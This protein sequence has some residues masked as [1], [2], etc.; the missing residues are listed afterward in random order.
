MAKLIGIVGESGTGKSTSLCATPKLGIKGLNPAET[1]VVNVVGESKD[2]PLKGWMKHYTAFHPTEN[3]EGNYISTA[4]PVKICY[5]VEQMGNR[6]DIKNIVI[7]DW[8]Y[9]MATEF[10]DNAAKAGFEKF[11]RLAANAWKVIK[12]CMAVPTDKKI[13]FLMHPEVIHHENGTVSYKIKTIGKMVDDKITMEGLFQTIIYCKQDYSKKEGMKK[14]F[15]TNNDG[16]YPSKTPIDMF[17]DLYM[18]NDLG[19]VVEAIDAYNS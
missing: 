19:V 16:V 12:A 1:A 11:N 3:P 15:V 17:D 13:F 8:Q 2:L 5:F 7:D 14:F 18:L 6:K 10:M 4:D 9:I